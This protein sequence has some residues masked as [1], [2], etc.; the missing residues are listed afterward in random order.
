MSVRTV[1][2]WRVPRAQAWQESEAELQVQVVTRS[3]ALAA[4]H[5]CIELLHAVPNGDWRG[6]G[7]GR[8]L[9]AQ[10]VIPGI[11]D[12]HLPVARGG[13]HSLYLE[14]KKAGGTPTQDQWEVM[15][16]LHAE[17]NFVR[18]TNSLPMALE[19]ITNYLE[20]MP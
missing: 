14:I 11:P 13:F 17:G 12:L 4:R 6:W 10:G 3:L 18:L 7:T 9:K 16:A 15:E 5:P 19:I 8:K 1:I 20:E 2:D